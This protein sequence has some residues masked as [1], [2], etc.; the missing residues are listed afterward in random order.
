MR[1]GL[2]QGCLGGGAKCNQRQ[3]MEGLCNSFRAHGLNPLG[4]MSWETHKKL[5][6]AYWMCM[7]TRSR[8]VDGWADGRTCKN[9]RRDFAPVS[10]CMVR[11]L[12]AACLLETH[13][14]L[15][16]AYCMCTPTRSRRMGGWV[17][18][19]K[20]QEGLCNSFRAH[21]SNPLGSMF[22]QTTNHTKTR[23]EDRPRCPA[24]LLRL[25]F[26]HHHDLYPSPWPLIHSSPCASAPS[27]L[28]ALRPPAS[29]P[30]LVSRSGCLHLPRASSASTPPG[31]CPTPLQKLV[32][33]QN[34]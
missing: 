33:R 2:E 25:V 32:S 24:M 1:L 15:V 31:C 28:P 13:K 5:V 21:G 12:W 7:Q 20:F 8:R 9:F 10:G 30:R 17:D 6:S 34:K 27:S 26:T 11:T 4:S 29:L 22:L 19:Q 3:K 16:S 23:F 18:L 14:K